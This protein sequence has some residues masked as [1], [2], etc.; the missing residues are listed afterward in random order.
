[1]DQL[2]YLKTPGQ[3]GNSRTELT[4]QKTFQ[5]HIQLCENWLTPTI[6]ISLQY[7]GDSLDV[8]REGLRSVDGKNPLMK[9][10]NSFVGAAL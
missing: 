2:L 10:V 9:L 1:M 7:T 4:V 5:H 6:F 3:D 8:L